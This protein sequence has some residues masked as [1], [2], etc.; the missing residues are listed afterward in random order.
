[1]RLR[2]LDLDGALDQQAAIVK[3]LSDG[4]MTRIEA[5]D[6][7]ASLRIVANRHAYKS[8]QERVRQAFSNGDG[9]QVTFYG[10]GDFHHVTTALIAQCD[11]PLTV[12]HF[13]HHPDWVTFPKTH[14][15]GAWVNRALELDQVARV[16]TLGPSSD[17]L[18]RPQWQFANLA[19]LE[20]GELALFP[21]RHAPSKVIGS[22]APNPCYAFHDGA[23]HWHCL[24]GLSDEAILA[25][26]T[27]LI[28]TEKVYVTFDKDVLSHKD[29]ATN[30]D[31][32][33]M[34]LEMVCAII[35][36]VAQRYQ[37]VGLD[38][39][40]DWSPPV[41]S[42]PFRWFLSKT[43]R[44]VRAPDPDGLAINAHTNARLLSLVE[45]LFAS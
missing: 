8:L 40:G 33:F 7:G 28:T 14:N 35:T 39:C 11:G 5:R 21:F 44:N 26:I 43:D 36:S 3:A 9:P 23:L 20:A 6:L 42:D 31:Q 37:I 16:I 30:W 22:F 34:A 19:A 13:D 27:P 1:M 2:L 15:C 12:L 10:S 45:D 32:G 4:I 18:N 29:A 17:D 41:F 24:E 25:R 38:I